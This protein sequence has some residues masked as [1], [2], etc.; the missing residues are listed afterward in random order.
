VPAPIIAPGS[1]AAAPEIADGAFFRRHLRRPATFSADNRRL[2]VDAAVVI[3]LALG[4]RLARHHVLAP[5]TDYLRSEPWMR[6]SPSRICWRCRPRPAAGSPLLAAVAWLVSIMS[7]GATPHDSSTG[8]RPRAA[9][10]VVRLMAA[11]QDEVTVS[12]RWLPHRPSGRL[13]YRH[14]GGD[15][16]ATSRRRRAMR[17]LPSV[18]FLKPTGR[19]VPDASSRWRSGSPLCGAPIAAHASGPAMYCGVVMSEESVPPAGRDCSPPQ[20]VVAPRPQPLAESKEPSR[21]GMLIS[22]FIRLWCAL[23]EIDPHQRS[24]RRSAS[25]SRRAARRIGVLHAATGSCTEQ[26]SDDTSRRSSVPSGWRGWRC[27]PAINHRA[28]V[29]VARDLSTSCG[30]SQLFQFCDL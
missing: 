27:A 1:W 2:P 22:P 17:T 5:A 26:G 23:L 29:K 25:F 3:A 10:F 14:K 16:R 12:F 15:A 18:P 19:K 11:A 9:W 21:I 24:S 8:R 20:H 30:Y 13:G 4:E 7:R 28:R 6:C